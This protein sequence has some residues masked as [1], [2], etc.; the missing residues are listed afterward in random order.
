MAILVG[1]KRAFCI[2][3]ACLRSHGSHSCSVQS[4]RGCS[5]MLSKISAVVA[6]GISVAVIGI[7]GTTSATA[8][9]TK[10]PTPLPGALSVGSTAAITTWLVNGN[11]KCLSVANGGSTADGTAIIQWSCNNGPEQRWAPYT[12]G[13]IR[14]DNGKCLSV[15]AGG[16]TQEGTA[17]IQYRCLANAP[18][19]VWFAGAGSSIFNGKTG[20]SISVAN[21]GSTANGTPIIQWSY[22]G[23]PEQQWSFI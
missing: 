12:D 17:L 9:E 21:G 20:Y 7:A 5:Q 2:Y 6:A 8:A 16:S 15:A 3:L 18:E 22:N 11:G 4:T 1:Q 14:N 10:K 23:G 13:T 19:Q